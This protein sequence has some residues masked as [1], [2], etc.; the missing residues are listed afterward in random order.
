MTRMGTDS[1]AKPRSGEGAK[2]AGG[3]PIGGVGDCLGGEARQYVRGHLADLVVGVGKLWEERWHRLAGWRLDPQK[4]FDRTAA[5]L[6]RRRS[7]E[8][9]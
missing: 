9:C 7:A 3:L 2:E 6:E 5:P 4:A 8:H 1:N